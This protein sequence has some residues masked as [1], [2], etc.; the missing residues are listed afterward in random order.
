MAV[1][2]SKQSVVW[3]DLLLIKEETAMVW[4]AITATSMVNRMQ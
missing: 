4:L 3:L 1:L 2:L